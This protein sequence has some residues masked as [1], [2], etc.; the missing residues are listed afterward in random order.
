MSMAKILT[1]AACRKLAPG[2]KRRR[3]RDAGARSLFLIVESSGHKAWQMR[4]RRPDGRPGKITLGPFDLTGLEIAGDPQIGQPLTLQAARQLAATVHRDR[5]LGRDVV[6]DHKARRH[7]R[8]NE[9]E[10]RAAST[11]AA[12]VPAYIDEYA[13]PETRGWRTTA[14][15]LGLRYAGDAAPEETK[16]GL[17]QR[18]GDRPVGTIDAHDVWAVIDEA[19]RLAIPGIKPHLRGLSEARGRALF[20]AISGMFAWLKRQRR[21]EINPVAGVSRPQTA[22]SRDRVLSADEIRWFWRACDSL[23]APAGPALKLMLLL[24]QRRSEVAGMVRSELRDDGTWLIPGARTKNAKAH[25]VPLAAPA[26]ELIAIVPGDSEY[27][28]T[29]T[30]R[31]PL[32]GWTHIKA[33]L[34]AAMLAFAQ[35]ERGPD[36]EIAAFRFHDLRR[37]AITGMAEIGIRPDVIELTVNH[38][39]GTRAGV[40]GTYNKAE[41]LDERRT[42]LVRWAAHVQGLVI[43]RPANVVALHKA[44]A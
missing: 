36:A 1:D 18:W 35:A 2:A 27:V 30:G 20:A 41:M 25:V 19:R 6:A 3:I 44:E 9:I 23:E 7:R 34:D 38:V 13:R 33:R 37:T 42:A 4:F 17:V 43:G 8:R 10:E 32:S 22:Q 21:I 39:S 15:Y 12:S 29:N 16:D 28:F 5:A 40:A 24:G 26:R 31:T 11:F 14:L